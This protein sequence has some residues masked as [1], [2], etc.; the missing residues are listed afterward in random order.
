M[1]IKSTSKKNKLNT[2]NIIT[3]QNDKNNTSDED[4]TSVLIDHTVIQ[5]PKTL[6]IHNIIP[7]PVKN[8]SSNPLPIYATQ[9]C[10]SLI[11]QAN[12]EGFVLLE[13]FKRLCIP[14]G[15]S[16]KLPEDY[17]VLVI[18]QT[19]LAKNNGITILNAPEIIDS[20]YCDE[21]KVLLVNLGTE[22]FLI[23]KG[24]KI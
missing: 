16:I 15:V 20:E 5:C 4:S 17:Y 1:S 10:T 12:V 11:L 13:P 21:I 9:S 2:S 3:L 24:T 18:P 7:V 6:T 19:D 8:K 14:T 22:N 23:T